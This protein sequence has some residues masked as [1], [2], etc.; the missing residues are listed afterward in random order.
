MHEQSQCHTTCIN[1][2]FEGSKHIHGGTHVDEYA[3]RT[4]SIT[5]GYNVY[6]ITYFRRRLT[7]RIVTRVRLSCRGDIWFQI[8]LMPCTRNYLV[9]RV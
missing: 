5:N 8:N 2:L 1:G 9:S 7:S 3:A 6:S 4:Q